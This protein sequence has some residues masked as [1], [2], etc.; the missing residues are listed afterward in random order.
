MLASEGE[1]D[2]VEPKTG[3]RQGYS[4]KSAMLWRVTHVSV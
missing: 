1:A 3:V 4:L 2:F